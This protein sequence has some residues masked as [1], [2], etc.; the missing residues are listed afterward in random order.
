MRKTRAAFFTLMMA[1]GCLVAAAPALAQTWPAKPV[2]IVVPFPP[3]GFADIFGRVL[4]EKFSAAWGQP[5]VVENR[6]GGGGNIGADIVA[7]SAGDGY[8]LVMGTVGT[9]AI[10]ATL[11]PNLPYDPVKDF[12]PVAFV[13]EAEGLLV[14]HPSVAAKSV[15]ELIALAKN[16]SDLSYGSAGAGTT[17]HLGGELFKTMAKVDI[18]HVPYKGN[19]PAIT[20]LLGGQ[21]SLVFA[22]LPTV[23]AHVKADKLRAVAVLGTARSTALPDVPTVAEAGLPGYDVNNWTGLFAGPGTSAII[24]AKIN[25]EVQRVMHLPEVQARLTGEGLR[26]VPTTPVQ[27]AGF[28]KTE[29]ARWGPVVKASGAKVD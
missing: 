1:L 8:T 27:F 26:F 18:T 7:K 9:H 3:G 5:V 21:T 4:A 17:G 28:V 19:V 15:K 25:A 6:A 12:T 20:D 10:N 14:A 29:I 23:L 13:V 2:R 24:V 16:R 11:F 22:T